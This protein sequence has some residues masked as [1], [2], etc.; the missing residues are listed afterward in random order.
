MTVCLCMIVRNEA[1]VILRCLDSVRP[2]IDGWL[3]VD[4]GS[5]DGTQ[6]LIRDHM[7]DIPGA[8]VERPWIDFG[9]NRTQALELAQSMADYSLV[10][11]ADD[12]LENPPGYTLP[13]LTADSYTFDV[14]FAPLRYQ[15]TQLFSNCLNWRY[16]GVLHEFPEAEGATTSEHLPLTIRV[17]NDGAR[18]Q[19]P[20]KYRKDALALTKAL[21]TETDPFMVSRYTFYLA[22]SW[23]DAGEQRL[24]LRHYLA[25]ADMGHWQSEV[26]V[27][28]LNAA[29]LREGLEHVGQQI[30]DGYRAAHEASPDRAEALHGA[31]RYCRL[32]GQPALGYRFAKSGIGLSAP[33]G[34]FVEPWVYDYGILDELA[35]NA[36][37]AGHYRECVDA[38]EIL[39]SEGKIPDHYRSRIIANANFARRKLIGA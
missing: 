18:R 6:A 1:H 30:L 26:Y 25:R 12:V 22:Q 16:R 13:P 10:I 32:N 27:S 15:R 37:W 2:F 36:Y 8:L 20:E 24:A 14:D 4:T 28:L 5:T 31:A 33:A 11:D 9:T 39:L 23:R 38:C 21:E 29:R 34:L 3:I 19:D 35:I 7:H 17:T